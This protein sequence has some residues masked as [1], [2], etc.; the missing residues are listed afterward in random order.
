MLIEL[1]H[2]ANPFELYQAMPGWKEASIDIAAVIKVAKKQ[3]DNG[4]DPQVAYKEVKAVLHKY[5][6]W[7]AKD[8]EPCWAAAIIFC[9]GMKLYP[10]DFY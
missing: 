9:Q 1:D 5:M 10:S 8:S 2:D 3:V 4:V 6:D 7:G